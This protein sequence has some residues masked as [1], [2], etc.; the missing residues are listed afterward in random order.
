[1]THWLGDELSTW[2]A[3]VWFMLKPLSNCWR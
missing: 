2:V 1:M 3:W